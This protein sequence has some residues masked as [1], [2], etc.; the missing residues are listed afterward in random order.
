MELKKEEQICLLS[1]I[2][3]TSV[4]Q[5]TKKHAGKLILQVLIQQLELTIQYA[6]SV[7]IYS[8]VNR[9]HL[10]SVVI[11]QIRSQLFQPRNKDMKS[12]QS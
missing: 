6:M 4:K 11:T 7:K 5:I 3:T 2:H 9:A 12:I 10:A 1:R 8:E